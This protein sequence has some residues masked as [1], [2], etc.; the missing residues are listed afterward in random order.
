M[1]GKSVSWCRAFRQHILVLAKRNRLPA[2]S[3]CGA[4]RPQLTA[5]QGP[6]VERRAILA[7]TRCAYR[8]GEGELTTSAILC[9]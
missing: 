1:P 6:R 2:D 9:D 4:Y 3:P 7:R 5:A 8:A